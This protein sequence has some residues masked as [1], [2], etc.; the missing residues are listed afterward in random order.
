MHIFLIILSVFAIVFSNYLVMKKKKTLTKD[1][2]FVYENDL[3]MK[4]QFIVYIQTLPILIF[5][6]LL[7]LTVDYRNIYF[8]IYLGLASLI[9]ILI[10]YFLVDRIIKKSELK[11]ELKKFKNHFL[12]RGLGEFNLLIAAFFILKEYIHY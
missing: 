1:Q 7:T 11:N 6:V 9:A 4:I 8:F 12:L 2:L 3:K 10:T 5:A